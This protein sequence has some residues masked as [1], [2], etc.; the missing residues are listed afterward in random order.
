MGV[1]Q[2]GLEDETNGCN[3]GFPDQQTEYGTMIQAVPV[4]ELGLVETCWVAH[5]KSGLMS[6]IRC[7]NPDLPISPIRPKPIE[8]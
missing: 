8:H 5:L 6:P 3:V 2:V 4:V 7:S 1:C